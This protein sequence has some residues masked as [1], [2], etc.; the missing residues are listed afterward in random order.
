MVSGFAVSRLLH[1][2]CIPPT[3]NSYSVLESIHALK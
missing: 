1:R 3:S 2:L